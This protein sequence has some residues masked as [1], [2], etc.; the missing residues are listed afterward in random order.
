LQ[1]GDSDLIK[2][3]IY[4]GLDASPIQSPLS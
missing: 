1:N 4:W 2:A 3:E